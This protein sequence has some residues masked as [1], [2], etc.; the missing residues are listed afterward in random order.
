VATPVQANASERSATQSA[1]ESDS[2]EPGKPLEREISSG[3]SH[4]YKIMMNSGQYLHV[5]VVQRGID[6]A[7]ALFTPDGKKISEAD[8]HLIGGS[9]SVLAIAEAPG[10]YQIEVRPPEKTALH[11]VY[12][13]QLNADLIVLSACETGLG[14]EIKGEGLIGLTREF[15]YSGAPRVIAS[16]WNVDDLA[17]AELM[18]LF[19]QRMLKDGMPAGAAL[20]AAQLELSRQKRWAS[21]YF[22]AGFVL[23]GEWK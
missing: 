9:E 6:V 7:V 22:W 17:T 14:K 18:K 21:P 2:L 4:S 16:L 15:M 20:R 5:V 3:Q 10:I 19:Y 11:E 12:N 13:L 1:Q 23:H 8:E